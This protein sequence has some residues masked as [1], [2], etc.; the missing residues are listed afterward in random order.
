[1]AESSTFVL[2]MLLGDQIIGELSFNSSTENFAVSYTQAWRQNGFPLSPMIPFDGSGTSVQIAMFLVNLLP[3]NKGLDYL[4]ESLGVA[5]GNTFALIRAIGLD[6]AGAIVFAAKR[7]TFGPTRFRPISN[8]EIIQ[9]L[10]DPEFWPMEIWDAKPRLS[11][12]GVQSKLNLFFNG[13]EF[14]FG[15]GALSST[16][17]LKFEKHPH[18]VI[19]EFL[20]MRL[21]KA[22]SMNVANVEIR[23]FGRHKSLCVERFDRRY[24]VD[25][26]RVQRRHIIDSCQA[27]GFSVN[28][29]YER[30]F[31]SGRD[32]MDI[33]E[34]VSLPRLFELASQCINP[35]AAK[36]DM[37]QWT[38]FNLLSGNAD[39]HGKNYSFYMTPNGMKPTPWYD[40]VCV[41]LY[42]DFEQD[43]AMAIDDE[44]DPNKIYAYQLAAFSEEVGLSRTLV[45]NS[46]IKMVTKIRQELDGVIAMLNELNSE[47]QIFVTK[48]QSQLLA[49]CE[50]YL[51]I[52]SE[53]K[54]ITL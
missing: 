5:R 13:E 36:L 35:A 12:A 54:T 38:L 4:I 1:M 16:H 28:K 26:N 31:G 18:L 47:E 15:E 30:N 42:G 52:A 39:A 14:G 50:R 44:F 27:L 48:Y 10:E 19:N 17:I 23:C 49:R 32:V 11:V 40:L 46:L 51:G 37:L 29:K 21:A 43:L 20:T 33:R 45:V 53:I 34:G 8:D 24:V 3:E 22:L 7:A 2:D 41:A 25:E 9:R 6:T